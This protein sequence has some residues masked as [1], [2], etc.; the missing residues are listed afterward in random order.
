MPARGD[1]YPEFTVPRLA[2]HNARAILSH[3]E[4]VAAI[5]DFSQIFFDGGGDHRLPRQL[6]AK[7]HRCLKSVPDE[8]RDV[9]RELAGGAL[10]GKGFLRNDYLLDAIQAHRP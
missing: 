4:I 3:G 10:L 5:V 8:H 7:I 2:Q 6:L 9:H 1:I